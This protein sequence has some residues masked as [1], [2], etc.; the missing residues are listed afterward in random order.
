[1]DRRDYER[2][3]SRYYLP[4]GMYSLRITGDT[5]LAQDVVQEVFAGLWRRVMEG[6]AELG[7]PAS[8]LYRAVRNRSLSAVA[9]KTDYDDIDDVALSEPVTEEDVDTSERDA[10]LWCEIGKLPDRMREIF[11][12]NKRDGMKYR[13]IAEELSL[14]EKTVEH[15]ISRALH[16][17]RESLAPSG[18]ALPLSSFSRFCKKERNESVDEIFLHYICLRSKRYLILQRFNKFNKMK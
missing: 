8:Y 5:D 3:F 2:L 9:G 13:E 14:S 18:K 6:N 4:L 7:S 11:L 17:L 15:Q 10:R 1:M 12:M 16:R